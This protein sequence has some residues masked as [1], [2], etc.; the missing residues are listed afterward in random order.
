[1]LTVTLTMRTALVIAVNWAASSSLMLFQKGISTM[2]YWN[3]QALSTRC[4]RVAWFFSPQMCPDVLRVKSGN[5]ICDA[6]KIIPTTQKQ[7]T[8]ANNIL[9]YI[10]WM[11]MQTREIY[12]GGRKSYSLSGKVLNWILNQ[13]T[14]HCGDWE[15]KE[16]EL[17]WLSP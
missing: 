15:G 5:L 10:Y 3:I 7:W 17:S 8:E 14:G 11:I 1:M 13:R 9:Q 12:N 6:F 16:G 2:C 4:S